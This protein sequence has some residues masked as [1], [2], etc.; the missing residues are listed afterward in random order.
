MAVTPDLFA[1]VQAVEEMLARRAPLTVEA[2]LAYV[3]ELQLATA[4]LQVLM[5]LEACT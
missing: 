1:A 5:A 4:R 2:Q 3:V